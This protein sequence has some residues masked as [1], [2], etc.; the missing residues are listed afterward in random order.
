MT[1]AYGQRHN[2]DNNKYYVKDHQDLGGG[3]TTRWASD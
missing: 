3:K 2:N 1:F